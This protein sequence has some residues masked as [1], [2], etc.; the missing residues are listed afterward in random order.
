MNDSIKSALADRITPAT[1]MPEWYFFVLIIAVLFGL[2]AWKWLDVQRVKNE[3]AKGGQAKESDGS[4]GG[5]RDIVIQM[6]TALSLHMEH[7]DRRLTAIEETQEDRFAA[8]ERKLDEGF[9]AIHKRMDD[10]IDNHSFGR[11]AGT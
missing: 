9:R 4:E 11:R 7:Q 5:L 6:K 10:H 2:L 8:F 1:S 3:A